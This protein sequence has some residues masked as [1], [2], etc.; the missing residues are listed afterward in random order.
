MRI[1]TLVALLPLFAVALLGCEKSPRDKLQGKWLG[2][3]VANVHPS[4]RDSADGWAR[5][6]SLEFKGRNVTVGLPAEAP[7]RGTFSVA[8]IEGREVELV[9]H[10]EDGGKDASRMRLEE[11]GRITWKLG[12]ADVVLAKAEP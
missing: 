10:R 9:F 6:M 1:G 4:Q 8:K 12:G 5:G 7:R 3:G 2:Q 11:D